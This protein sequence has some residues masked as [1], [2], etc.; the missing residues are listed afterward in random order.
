MPAGNVQLAAAGTRL[1]T[2]A[3][4]KGTGV[5]RYEF[6]I[7]SWDAHVQG[8]VSH[9]GKRRGDLRDDEN[10]IIG[11][12]PDYTTV[13]LSLGAEGGNYRVEL[14]ALNVFDSNGRYSTALQCQAVV[15]GDPDGISG[16]GGVFYDT[17]VRP[18][19][20]GLRVGFDF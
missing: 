17:V 8:A 14:F 19:T 5:A 7:G 2:T 11:T 13:D 18:R 3:R 16:T 12:L 9:T 20:I 1:P 15:C 6:P 10:A 4:F